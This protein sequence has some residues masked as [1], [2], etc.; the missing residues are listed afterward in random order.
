MKRAAAA[1]QERASELGQILCK[2][3]MLHTTWKV[4]GYLFSNFPS[5]FQRWGWEQLMY[6][7][8]VSYTKNKMQ[9]Y[10]CLKSMSIFCWVH[11][12]MRSLCQKK[13]RVFFL[14]SS[15]GSIFL[16]FS[17]FHLHIYQCVI[18]VLMNLLLRAHSWLRAFVENLDDQSFN[19]PFH[20]WK[21]CMHACGA[22]SHEIGQLIKARRHT[23]DMIQ[24]GRL[25]PL[26]SQKYVKR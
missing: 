22:S 26:M 9:V 3:E 13:A 23:N 19:L 11:V 12:L 16:F 5:I 15:F 2:T 10:K 17:S 8:R 1:A 4:L 6:V 14:R 21:G 20:C 25:F 7:E 24:V 18:P